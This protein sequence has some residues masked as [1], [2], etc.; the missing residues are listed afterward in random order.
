MKII[1]KRYQLAKHSSKQY[2]RR[3]RNQ[4]KYIAFHHSA[5]ISGTVEQFANY[6]VNHLDWPGIGYHYV[7]DKQGDI[8][9]CHDLETISY[10][11]GNSNKASVGIC[12][13]GDFTKGKPTKAQYE[14]TLKLTD[15]LMN[16]LSIN[17]KN[18]L[19]HNQ[20]PNNSTACPAINMNTFREDVKKFQENKEDDEKLKL[21]SY[22][23]KVLENNMK[24]LLKDKIITDQ[25]WLT[26]IQNK[27][28][29]VSELAWINNIIFIRLKK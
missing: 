23:W 15:M 6:H 27:T 18:V 1:D 29:T 11:V 21:T 9:W 14:S 26:K 10:H 13:I 24:K 28:L 17:L 2:S 5:S 16:E 22:Q 12:L 19:G 25:A 7:V 4:I 20:F 3:S 8:Y